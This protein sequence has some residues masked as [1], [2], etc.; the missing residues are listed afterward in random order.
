MPGIR[1]DE[2]GV[3][4]IAKHFKPFKYKN[5]E[6][7]E[8]KLNTHRSSKNSDI[9]VGFSGGRDSSYMLHV[10][11]TKY[12]MNPI[13]ITYDWGM[14]TD[15]ARRNQARMCGALGIEHIIVAADIPQKRDYI[16]NYL[17]AW[18]K[19][20]NLG[21]VLLLM[22]GDKNIFKQSMTLLKKTILI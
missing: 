15:L 20:P 16:K 21:M 2:A 14:V 19:K 22:A 9:I 18:L 11:K 7:L 4:N 5:I 12:D 1:F 6:E 3:S 10:L 13:A 17:N 8:N